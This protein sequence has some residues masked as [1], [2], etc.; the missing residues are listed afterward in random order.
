MAPSNSR[1][2][3][4]ITSSGETGA[5]LTGSPWFTSAIPRSTS[6]PSASY[7][8]D[9]GTPELRATRYPEAGD[10]CSSAR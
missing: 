1:L 6:P 2:R 7:T 3:R 8:F 4:E 10:S 9:L 5:Y